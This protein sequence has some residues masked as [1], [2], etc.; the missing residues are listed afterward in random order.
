MLRVCLETLVSDC[1]AALLWA[2]VSKQPQY[3]LL[4]M[5]G[6]F[7]PL[8]VPTFV[9]LPSVAI[10]GKLDSSS[11]FRATL[12]S[13]TCALPSSLHTSHARETINQLTLIDEALASSV[14]YRHFCTPCYNMATV[15]SNGG[16]LEGMDK[17]VFMQ[18]QN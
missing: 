5:Y 16:D 10:R 2:S 7:Q 3:T 9:A 11:P 18:A 4:C 14:K 13:G 8:L 12:L 15:K 6:S 17:R 1:L